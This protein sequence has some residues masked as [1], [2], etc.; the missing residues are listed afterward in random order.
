MNRPEI[1]NNLTK[2]NNI[3]DGKITFRK[4]ER[5]SQ[6]DTLIANGKGVRN[7]EK[8]LI[9]NDLNWNPSDHA[10]VAA[11]VSIIISN[12]NTRYF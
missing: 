12:D 3:F 1:L 11:N 10:P 4:G 6:N 8:F 2:G 7:R 9:S 5:S